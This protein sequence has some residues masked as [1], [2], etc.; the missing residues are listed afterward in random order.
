M[1]KNINNS[2]ETKY[3]DYQVQ[4]NKIKMQNTF[5]KK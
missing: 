5:V 4:N 1:H 2:K 3:L